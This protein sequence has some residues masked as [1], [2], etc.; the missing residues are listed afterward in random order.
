MGSFFG[1][2]AFLPIWGIYIH[3]K[4]FFSPNIHSL[5]KPRIIRAYPDVLISRHHVLRSLSTL[6][7]LPVNILCRHLDITSLAVDAAG[8]RLVYMP[9]VT[10]M[11]VDTYFCELIWN[12]TPSFLLG[13]ST[14]S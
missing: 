1:S 14:Y 3:S 13:S 8:K 12:R 4:G 5:F 11:A 10:Q 6:R 9:Q 2:L 7:R